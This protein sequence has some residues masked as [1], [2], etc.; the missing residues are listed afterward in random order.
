MLTSWD[1]LRWMEA[2]DGIATILEVFRDFEDV[3]STEIVA[4][5]RKLC[6]EGRIGVLYDR[7]VFLMFE[8]AVVYSVPREPNPRYRVDLRPVPPNTPKP[9]RPK[10][11]N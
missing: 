4:A 1:L 7:Y 10:R 8:G 9:G 3:D 11:G 2:R 6:A 5:W